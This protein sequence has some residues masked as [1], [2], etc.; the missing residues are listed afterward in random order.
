MGIL[1]SLSKGLEQGRADVREQR[2]VAEQM[3]EQERL[4]APPNKVAMA[5]GRAIERVAPA[6]DRIIHGAQA[7][8]KAI[9]KIQGKKPVLQS[10]PRKP[11]PTQQ[12]KPIVVVM[13]EDRAPPRPRERAAPGGSDMSRFMP[14]GGS[15]MGPAAGDSSRFAMP[16]RRW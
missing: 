4:Q 3:R 12:G 6:K 16:K 9:D 15:G 11:A 14:S 7:A 8:D 2:R 5:F 10:R 13:R 1:D